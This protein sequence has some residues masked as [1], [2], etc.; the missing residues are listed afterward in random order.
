LALAALL[1]A[2]MASQAARLLSAAGRAESGDAGVGDAEVGGSRLSQI[3]GAFAFALA[4]TLGLL[5]LP[6]G[7]GA[8]V[9]VRWLLVGGALVLVAGLWRDLGRGVRGQALGALVVAALLAVGVTGVRM[10]TAKLPFGP[11]IELTWAGPMLTVAWIVAVA[12]VVR[13]LDPLPGLTAGFGAISAATFLIV[14]LTRGR[15]SLAAVGPLTPGLAAALLGACAGLIGPGLRGGLS[16]G[17]GGAGLLG[18]LLGVLTVV[19]TLKHTAFLL[20]ALPLLSLA[21]P[22]LNVVYMRRQWVRA[23]TDPA[24]LDR[25]GSLGDMLFRRGFTHSRSVELLLGLQ[26]WCSLV[27]L[28][29]VGLVTVPFILKLGLLLLVLPVAFAAFFLIT[30]IAARV[31]VTG[32]GRVD[33]LGVS[34]DA[35]TYATALERMDAMIRSGEPHH[36]FT[37]DVS[38]IMRARDEAQLGEIIRTADLVTADG[39]GVL[40]AARLFDFPL[41]ERVSGVDLVRRLCGLAAR[42]GYRVFLLGAAPGVAQAAAEVLRREHP[43]LTVCGV[44]DGYFPDAAQV[45]E[46]LR[47]ARPDIVFVALGIPT[48]ELFIRRWYRE[49]GLPLCLGVGGSFDVI[50]GRLERAPLWMQRAGLEWLFRLRQEPKRWRRMA[51]LPRFVWAIATTTWRAWVRG[52][53]VYAG[54]VPGD[55][56]TTPGAS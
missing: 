6:P 30:R 21:V 10:E 13:L 17:R 23:G 27:A 45:A 24:R 36:V 15:E 32:A 35:V 53:G 41:P 39:A 22:L 33:I 37:A 28:A 56:V 12:V 40:W 2:I 42:N 54:G 25:A 4:V 34:I 1:A 49:L 8:Q 5:A 44:Q 47:E 48:Q 26:A 29:L 46:L 50:S 31:A 19:G 18:Y 20:L 51:A 14:A 16:L 9:E 52:S 3:A 38:G 43:G 11:I 55:G 7:D